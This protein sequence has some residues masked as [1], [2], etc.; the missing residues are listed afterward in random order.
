MHT[1]TVNGSANIVIGGT[2][3]AVTASR[4]GSG[5]LFGAGWQ[6]DNVRYSLTHYVDVGATTDYTMFSVGWLF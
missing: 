6:D 5:P 3:Y 2:T 4:E 1:S